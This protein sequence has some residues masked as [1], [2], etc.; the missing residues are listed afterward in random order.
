[1]DCVRVNSKH[2]FTVSLTIRTLGKQH[3]TA[4]AAWLPEII[5]DSLAKD[6]LGKMLVWMNILASL[7][8][9]HHNRP[10]TALFY[11]ADRVS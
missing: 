2:D 1:M 5:A 7:P 8:V 10:T 3:K 4:L 9:A 11:V 6:C